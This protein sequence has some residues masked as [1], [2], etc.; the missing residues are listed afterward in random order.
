MP[1][2]D[3]PTLTIDGG[4]PAAIEVL[5]SCVKECEVL[6]GRDPDPEER[7]MQFWIELA[8]ECARQTY[9]ERVLALKYP[10]QN[11]QALCR[12]ENE[13]AELNGREKPGEKTP[14][15]WTNFALNAAV[16]RG[17][18]ELIARQK[19]VAQCDFCGALEKVDDELLA[20]YNQE[21]Y[22]CDAC[23]A[24]GLTA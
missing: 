3:L 2:G 10:D 19:E 23:I 24:G 12:I 9:Y 11:I 4:F 14:T 6:L 16:I 21:Q 1:D 13:L 17:T 5:A 20:K 18:E 7:S 8:V 22:L 15:Y